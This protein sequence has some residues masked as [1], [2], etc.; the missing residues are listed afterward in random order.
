MIHSILRP[1]IPRYIRHFLDFR[2]VDHTDQCIQ[3]LF[4][5]LYFL[6]EFG[7]LFLHFCNLFCQLCAGFSCRA[8]TEF[9]AKSCIQHVFVASNRTGQTKHRIFVRPIV[10]ADCYGVSAAVMAVAC[11][12]VPLIERV[13]IERMEACQCGCTCA[14]FANAA[15]KRAK[16]AAEALSADK[17]IVC[18]VQI[19]TAYVTVSYYAAA[20]HNVFAYRYAA[21]IYA[22]SEDFL[23]S[24]DIM[25][26]AD[27]N[28][29][30]H[31]YRAGNF[32]GS[33]KR[34]GAGYIK[35]AVNVCVMDV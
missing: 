34:G 16:P 7:V 21:M 2:H 8:G 27:C 1:V 24:C 12:E 22:V 6:R 14:D 31:K 28:I 13:V 32:Q 9:N 19:I 33:A 5:R 30:V 11:C 17:D 35:L 10:S 20:D 4:H 15:V 29:T 3:R 18:S 23:A 26:P 25:V